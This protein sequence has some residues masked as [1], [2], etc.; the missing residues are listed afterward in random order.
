MNIHYFKQARILHKWLG[1]ACFIF[2]LI[3]S[4]SG[5][6]LMHADS[7]ELDKKMIEGKF[8][9]NKYFQV[10]GAHRSVQSLAVISENEASIIF[11]GTDHGLFRSNDSGQSWV[12][13]KEGLFSQDIRVLAINPQDSQMIYAGTPKGIFKSEDQGDS[14]SEWFDEASGLTHVLI[15]D[16]L[17]NPN[18][19]DTIYAATQG[20][21]FV[22]HEEGE[23]WESVGNGIP[24]NQNVRTIRFSA[25]Y[26][27]NIIIGTENG[28]FRSADGGKL[29]EKKWNNL[30]PDI[31]SLITLNTDPEFIFVG[32]NKGFYK[33]FNGGL[34]WIKDSH[35][36]LKEIYTLAV[37]SKEHSSIYLSAKKGLFFSH[38]GGDTWQEITPDKNNVQNLEDVALMPINTILPIGGKTQPSLLFA[39]SEAGLFISKNNGTHW[40]FIDLGES[41]NTVSKENFKM[42]L[43]KLV[44]EIHTGRFLGSYFFWLVDLSSFGM[45]AL[46]I[47]GLMVVFYRGKMK[48]SKITKKA[49]HDAEIDIDH[50]IEIAE[51]ADDLSVDSQNVHEMVEHIC[52]HL[53]KCKTIY[54]ITQEKEEIEKIGY[55]I[56]SLDKKL[57][58][59]MEHVDGFA[60]ITQDMDAK[61]DGTKT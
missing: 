4:A 23:F 51:S 5:I 26:P 8:L 9:P 33:S 52:R 31:S 29:W 41:G 2:V 43:S 45:I 39:G 32:T 6:L 40:N 15:N 57:N 59:M 50:N 11:A 54:S 44:T 24:S 36:K 37:D 42:D 16:L 3:L 35:K 22:S 38:N 1:V 14:W 48:T 60:K 25:T 21:L 58:Q 18:D 27:D 19:T 28:T 13:L 7:L 46:A 55:H 49:K 17:I 47:S 34:N 61:E 12:E 10:V 53:E 20:G 56:L 30:P